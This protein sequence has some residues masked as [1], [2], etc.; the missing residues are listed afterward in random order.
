MRKEVLNTGREFVLVKKKLEVKRVLEST[1]FPL[2]K[3]PFVSLQTS[4][5]KVN[6]HT[7]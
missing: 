2:S 3:D 7:L 4:H 5:L 1:V 6:S